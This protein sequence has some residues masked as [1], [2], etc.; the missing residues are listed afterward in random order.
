M[1]TT[2][3][4]SATDWREGRRLR[5]WELHELGWNQSQI[6]TALGVTSGAVSQWMRRF[7]EGGG[8]EVLRKRKA[9]G[10]RPRL[11]AEQQAQILA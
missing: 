2:S 8:A 4:A 11:S 10:G 3:S 5:V 1:S 9:P 7:P 6:A